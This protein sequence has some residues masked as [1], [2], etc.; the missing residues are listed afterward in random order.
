MRRFYP[1]ALVLFLFALPALACGT[2]DALVFSPDTLPPAQVGQPYTAT[3]TLS[4]QRTPAFMFDA[5]HK[6][7]PPG[8]TTQFNQDKQTLT[9][10]GT[11]TQAGQFKITVYAHCYGTNISGQSGEKVYA[12]DVK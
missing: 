9:F 11:P 2:S 7:I 12:L 5:D 10:G 1:L 4:N 6:T 3:L 8:L